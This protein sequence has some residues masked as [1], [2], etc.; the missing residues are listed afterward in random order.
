M[1]EENSNK[2]IENKIDFEINLPES[3]SSDNNIPQTV[4]LNKKKPK[5]ILYFLKY[6]KSEI[7]LKN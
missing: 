1:Q 4:V 3:N 6:Q 5:G 7:C 2:S